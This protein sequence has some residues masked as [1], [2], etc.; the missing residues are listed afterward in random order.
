MSYYKKI[1]P[2]DEWE[3]PI[4]LFES[5]QS[6]FSLE[7]DVCA[8]KSNC[9]LNKYFDKEADGLTNDWGNYRCWMNPPYSDITPWVKKA[10]EHAHKGNICIA[11]LP[12]KTDV[13]WF[14]E[15]IYDKFPIRFIKGRL[16]F[17]NSK[18]NAPFPSMLVI[19][20]T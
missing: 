14:H 9:K 4:S 8:T 13:R 10:S 17:R 11:L 12:A 15:F 7:L 3:T 19:F 6:E 2:S 18:D 5:I 1:S 20:K 16:K